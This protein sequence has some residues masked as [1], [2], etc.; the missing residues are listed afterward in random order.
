MS[1]VVPTASAK[2]CNLSGTIVH[3]H[4]DKIDLYGKTV[5]VKKKITN[6]RIFVLLYFLFRHHT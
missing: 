6:I 1:E 5:K 4:Y 3:E 2:L